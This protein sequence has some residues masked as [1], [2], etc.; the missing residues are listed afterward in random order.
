MTNVSCREYYDSLIIC[1]EGHTGFAQRGD[2]IVCAAISA[3]AFTFM[4]C[5]LNE[6]AADN[7]K[8]IR[9]IVR[10]G[11]MYFEFKVYDFSKERVSGIVDAL[12]TGFIML[13]ENYPQYVKYN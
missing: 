9:K 1:V 8:F 5:L 6:E 2:D 12:V 13:E 4:N 11:Y 10:D 3:L 7:I